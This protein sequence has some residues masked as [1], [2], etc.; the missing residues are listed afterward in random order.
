MFR[1]SIK[2]YDKLLL[3]RP[4]GRFCSV[5]STTQDNWKQQNYH[6]TH[7]DVLSKKR[8]LHSKDNKDGSKNLLYPKADF[9]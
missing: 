2:I 1:V 5:A 9:G 6:E 8:Q 7:A 3:L 4:D